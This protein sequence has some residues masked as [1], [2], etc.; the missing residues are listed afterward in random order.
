MSVTGTLEQP[1]PAP[2]GGEQRLQYL[3][4]W[5]GGGPLTGAPQVAGVRIPYVCAALRR[6]ILPSCELARYGARRVRACIH[7]GPQE[8]GGGGAG[9][10]AAARALMTS[11]ATYCGVPQMVDMVPPGSV[12]AAS[13]K[14][15][16]LMSVMAMGAA[17][18]RF[19]SFRSRWATPL[20][21]PSLPVAFQTGT[22]QCDASCAGARV[23]N[24]FVIENTGP[25]EVAIRVADW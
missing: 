20:G 2:Q 10:G 7:A 16:I 11:G 23:Y 5:D 4:H 19:S 21:A 3:S 14:S 8:G 13:P 12:L 18:S 1:P 17:S 9:E 25:D 24:S 22:I 15:A 6:A